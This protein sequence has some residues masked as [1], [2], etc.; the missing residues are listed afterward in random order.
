MQIRDL[1]KPVTSSQLNE[2]MAK[3]FG[4]KLNLEQF[5]DV[6]LSDVQN[7]LRTEVSQFEVNEGFDQL[8]SNPKYQKT[9]ALLDVINQAVLEQSTRREA[10]ASKHQAWEEKKLGSIRES[11][12][13]SSR[14][15]S[16]LRTSSESE[17]SSQF[18]M[19]DPSEL[20]K[21]ESMRIAHQEKLRNDRFAI[22]KNIE[23]EMFNNSQQRSKTLS[24]IYNSINLDIED[25]D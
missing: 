23:E 2:S 20:D 21:R 9:R 16:I 1:S 15:N 24:E 7:K 18:G 8:H 14:A 5:S 17:H 22:K 25:I 11:K 12:V 4:Y 6:Q 10:K 13:V 3:S 19:I